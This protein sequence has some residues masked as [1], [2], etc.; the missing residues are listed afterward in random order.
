[1][2]DQAT[3]PGAAQWAAVAK[4]KL[5]FIKRNIYYGNLTLLRP[6]GEIPKAAAE[7]G[8]SPLKTTVSSAPVY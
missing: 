2:V 1:M 6:D 7:C 4:Q 3:A 8:E 5:N